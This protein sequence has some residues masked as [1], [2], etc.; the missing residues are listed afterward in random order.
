MKVRPV[1]PRRLAN[2]DVEAAIDHYLVEH[3]DQAAL[4]FVNA[5]DKA[6]YHLARHPGSGSAR[7]AHE[8]NLPELRCWPLKNY[9]YT[10]FY[11]EQASHI[12]VWRILHSRRDIPTEL[13]E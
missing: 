8:L 6:Y 10:I 7:Y 11:I 5:L 2:L 1:V 3:E 13:C 9:P 4:G 12:D